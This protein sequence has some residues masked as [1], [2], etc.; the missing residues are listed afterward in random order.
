[1]RTLQQA[2]VVEY[3]RREQDTEELT[4]CLH[5]SMRTGAGGMIMESDS[6]K[7]G[8]GKPT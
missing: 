4:P 1:M 6:D 7:G 2:T 3:E 5:S 8:H